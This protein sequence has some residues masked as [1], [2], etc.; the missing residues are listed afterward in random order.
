MSY[1]TL[2]G[3]A[4]LQVATSPSPESETGQIVLTADDMTFC[5]GKTGCLGIFLGA[6]H[7]ASC[8]RA[9]R[10]FDL[11]VSSLCPQ[12]DREIMTGCAEH[13]R[14][15]CRQL[16]EGDNLS[17]RFLILV[18]Q[19]ELKSATRRLG[20]SWWRCETTCRKCRRILGISS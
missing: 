16:V 1:E 5:F 3:H 4:Q 17:S 6:T 15:I 2:M 19:E 20:E 9:K 11:D 8:G 13:F 10:P 12:R 7:Y 18:L 14:I